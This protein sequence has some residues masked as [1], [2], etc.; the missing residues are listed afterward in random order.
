M[1]SAAIDLGIY[2]L[3]IV[4][5]TLVGSAIPLL[6]NWTDAQFRLLL[7][8][9]AGVLLGAAFLHMA[10]QA[11]N[12]I[13]ESTGIFILAGFVGLYIVEKYIAV[14]ICEARGCDV[15]EFGALGWAAFVGLSV[16]ALMDGVAL[17]SAVLLS[18]GEAATPHRA[19]GT[20]VFFAIFAHKGPSALALASILKEEKREP[21]RIVLLNV[22]FALMTPL[23]AAITLSSLRLLNTTAIGIATAISVGTFLHI[24]LSDLLPEVHKHLGNR[25][26]NLAAFLGGLGMM[27]LVL[28]AE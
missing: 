28:L 13:G 6:R 17:G 8:F 3:L 22:I 26:R 9:A 19:F 7:G 27:A 16:H 5:A 4:A 11:F 24:A 14:H 12:L 21:R 20:I 10:P 23:G 15:H 2:S 1:S 18:T 25:N